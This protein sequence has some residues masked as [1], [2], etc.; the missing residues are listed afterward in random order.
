[1]THPPLLIFDLDGTLVDS[2]AGICAACQAACD[3]LGYARPTDDVIRPMIGLSL[4]FLFQTVLPADVS[5]TTIDR[6]IDAYRI[7][8]DRIALPVT[9]TFPAVDDEL[10]RWKASGRQLAIA[11]SKRTDIAV[12][13][14]QK[15]NIFELFHIVVG[16]DQVVRGKPY[17]DMA[18]HVLAQFGLDQSHAAMIGD[19]AHDIG[20]ASAAGITAYAVSYGVHD[21]ETLRLANPQAIVDHFAD[22]ASIPDLTRD[23]W[24]G[25][26]SRSLK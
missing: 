14:L 8:F 16:A 13:V 23:Y 7:A 25:G 9:K 18:I 17:P 5:V 3:M 4:R 12:K 22:L 21:R 11:T 10:R 20:M 6:A 19:T 26:R 15:A 2:A 1:M 24:R